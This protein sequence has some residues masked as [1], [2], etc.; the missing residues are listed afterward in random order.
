ML[1]IHNL[2][3]LNRKSAEIEV[4]QLIRDI[5]KIQKQPLTFEGLHKHLAEFFIS[6]TDMDM[7]GQALNIIPD[8]VH[9]IVALSKSGGPYATVNM[10]RACEALEEIPLPLNNNITYGQTM[11]EWQESMVS[12]MHELLVAIPKLKGDAEKKAHDK[13]LSAV[14]ETILRN[15]EF[16][17]NY[18]DII[19]E[20]QTQRMKSLLD[21]ID[22]GFF[23]H[24]KLEDHLKK[25]N[26][27]SKQ[28]PQTDKAKLDE[29]TKNI[30]LIKASVDRAYDH[31]M[32]MLDLAIILYA[33]IRWLSTK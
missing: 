24:M 33:Y 14:F 21:S 5:K 22:K 8:T 1:Y 25:D 9:A 7:M 32:R 10:K 31:N 2:K 26:P 20:A 13:R 3:D 6:K 12:E 4:T 19:N 17:F 30:R 29:I 15:T 27:A 11:F 28:V 23:M 16:A 18:K